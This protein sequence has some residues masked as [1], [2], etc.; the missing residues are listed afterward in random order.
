MSDN[1]KTEVINEEDE[2]TATLE[3]ESVEQAD[4]SRNNFCGVLHGGRPDDEEPHIKKTLKRFGVK[5]DLILRVDLVRP[6][7]LYV[8][9][10]MILFQKSLGI[11]E[12][13]FDDLQSLF[14]VSRCFLIWCNPNLLDK[15]FFFLLQVKYKP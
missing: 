3:E 1:I 6:M 13:D 11:S 7:G 10:G 5:I 12:D 4:A 14:Q 8:L 9:I 15:M 2:V